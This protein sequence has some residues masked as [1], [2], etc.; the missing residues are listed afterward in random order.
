[1]LQASK[2]EQEYF[3]RTHKIFTKDALKDTVYKRQIPEYL[4]LME[5]PSKIA[6][7]LTLQYR[8]SNQGHRGWQDRDGYCDIQELRMDHTHTQD[9]EPQEA[10]WERRGC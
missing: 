9:N 5:D 7:M 10:A 8:E 6:A 2:D 3:K 1:M 4:R